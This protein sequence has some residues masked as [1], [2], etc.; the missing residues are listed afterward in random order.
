MVTWAG[1]EVVSP[2]PFSSSWLGVSQPKP[3]VYRLPAEI[4]L[5]LEKG[6]VDLN[7]P[8][9]YLRPY[10]LVGTSIIYTVVIRRD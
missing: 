5:L 7:Q 4:Q 10:P 3:F 9:T 1:T 6:K 8:L 2:L